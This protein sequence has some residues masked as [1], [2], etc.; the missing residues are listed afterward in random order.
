MHTWRA[1]PAFADSV[2]STARTRRS[3]LSSSDIPPRKQTS[4]QNELAFDLTRHFFGAESE[5]LFMKNWKDRTRRAS[6]VSQFCQLTTTPFAFF[7]C[8]KLVLWVIYV[9]RPLFISSWGLFSLLLLLFSKFATPQSVQLFFKPKNPLC[10][11][12]MRRDARMRTPAHRPK[13]APLPNQVKSSL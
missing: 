11:Q 13:A 2:D 9:F 4:T 5:A 8:L 12:I 7:F 6:R 1:P 10:L 3:A